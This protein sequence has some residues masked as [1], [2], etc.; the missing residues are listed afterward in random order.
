MVFITDLL[1][2]MVS[3]FKDPMMCLIIVITEKHKYYLR[4]KYSRLLDAE[5]MACLA[6]TADNAHTQ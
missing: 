2:R 1:C 4:N 6:V 5:R 3:G